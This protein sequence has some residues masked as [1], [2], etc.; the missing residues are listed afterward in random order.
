MAD[1]KVCGKCDSVISKNATSVE[2]NL[3]HAWYHKGCA[4]LTTS[5]FNKIW[6]Q[7]KKSKKHDW[8]C[9][10]CKDN[11]VRL[12]SSNRDS[13]LTSVDQSNYSMS[14]SNSD[15]LERIIEDTLVNKKN[16][17]MSDLCPIILQIFKEIKQQNVKM[18]CMLE[19]IKATNLEK[20]MKIMELENDILVLKEEV[21]ELKKVFQ[22]DCKLV[23]TNSVDTYKNNI[24]NEINDRSER[25]KNIIIY[26]VPESDSHLYQE[27]IQTDSTEIKRIFSKIQFECP[28]FKSIRL[29]KPRNG[30]RPLKTILPDS[31]LVALC[32]KKRG[33]LKD[34]NIRIGADL[35]PLQREEIK[36]AYGE[37]EK[38]TKNGEENLRIRYFKGSPKVVQLKKLNSKNDH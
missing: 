35:T 19:D 32:M 11:Q 21:V 38:R 37:M 28:S 23:N 9:T 4:S 17:N 7:F 13:M 10:Y 27:R 26:N 34:S 36:N 2:C 22:T 15:D 5:E 31:N 8:T 30:P 20:N 16:V 12:S 6:A 33:F 24:F 18:Q 14:N 25:A 29:G 3:C 1:E